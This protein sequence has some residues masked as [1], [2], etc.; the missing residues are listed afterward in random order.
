MASEDV[1][2]RRS[3]RLGELLELIIDYRGKTPKKLGGDFT[4]S[5]VPVIS[6]IH[7]KGGR[8]VWE[9]RERFV[10]KEMFDK[11][12][13]EP[14]RKDDVLLSSEAP[15]GEVALVPNDEDLVLSQRLFALRTKSKLIDPRYLKY[16]FQSS[17]GENE[18]QA[19]AS[20]STVIGIRQSEL[21]NVLVECPVL[22]EQRIIGA[23]LS[24]LDDKIDTNLQLS[25]T[26]EQIAQAFFKSWFIDFDPVKAKMAGEKSVGIDDATAALFPNSMEDSEFGPIPK[27]WMYKSANEI[28]DVGIGRTPPRKEPVWFCDGGNGID[29]VSIRDMGTYGVFA[30]GTNEGLTEE[31]VQKFR[32]PVV[33]EG[34]VLMSFKLTVGKLCITNRELVTNEA[35]AHFKQISDSPINSI[36]AYLWLSNQNMANLDSTSS[37]GTATNS[38]VV[39][40]IKFLIPSEKVHAAFLDIAGPIFDEIA[41]LTLQTTQLI[42]IRDALLPRLI[43][44]ELEIPKE[45]L[46][47]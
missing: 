40:A 46:V 39:K 4:S 38:E 22:E 5:G 18:L 42:G 47:L 29:W 3:Y 7:L 19:R 8:I 27:G 9:E 26:F 6:A 44:G 21:V 35:I 14:L 31:A 23:V 24:A 15:L 41:N 34:T 1:P 37:I 11:W 13:K 17:I 16:Y 43:S 45:M 32:V 33:P 12:M 2:S 30:D 25:R 28:F 36:F 10:S 20:G